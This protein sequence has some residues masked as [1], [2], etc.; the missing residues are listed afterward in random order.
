MKLHNT[1]TRQ[2]EEFNPQSN[3]NVRMYSCGPTVYDHIHIG[4]LSAYVYVDT[5]RRTLQASGLNVRHIMNFTD[6][7]DKTIK[8]SL[9]NYP[10]LAPEEAL[11]KLTTNYADI[12]LNDIADIGNDVFSTEFVY[13][14]NSIEGI[15][16]LIT[17]L[18]EDDFAYITDDGVYFSIEKYRAS[19]KKYGQLLTLTEENTS[20]ARIANDEYDKDYVHDFALWKVKKAGEPAWQ[21]DLDGHD[22]TGRPGWHVECS[23]MSVQSL[24]QPFDIHTGGVDNIFPHHENEIAQSTAGK[25]NLYA[26]YF[27]HNEHLL[28]D[29][30]KMSKSLNNFYRLQDI[31]EKGYDPLAFRLMV[32]QSHYRSQSNFTWENLDAAQTRLQGWRTV[33]DLRWQVVDN[34]SEIS[35]DNVSAAVTEYI[36]VDLNTPMAFATIST[37]FM[38]ELNELGYLPNNSKKSFIDFLTKLDTLL[39]LGLLDSNDINPQQ[40]NIIV[41]RQKARDAKDWAKSDEL[42]D[43]LKEQGVEVRDTD[44]GPIWSRI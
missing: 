39:G 16:Q 32:L 10:D 26:K 12:F 40:K 28:V 7:D 33:A 21:F 41:E 8:R 36:E 23:V 13:A 37:E 9:E 3:D 29:G 24:G 18:F 1:L 20:S 34:D 14:T 2:T 25:G 6:V 44:H 15:R 19:G 38:D 43:Q 22:L 27:V 5:L 4:N 42:R 11:K 30:K 17:E 35:F 31:K